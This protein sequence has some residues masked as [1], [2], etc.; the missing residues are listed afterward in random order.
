MPAELRDAPQRQMPVR[1]QCHFSIVQSRGSVVCV[2]HLPSP[3]PLPFP[4]SP[5]GQTFRPLA[6]IF[7]D[8]ETKASWL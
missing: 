7:V 2:L 5:V 4:R 1:R 6:A 3:A 8:I